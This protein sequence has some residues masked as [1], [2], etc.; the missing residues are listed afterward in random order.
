MAAFRSSRTARGLAIWA[1][2]AQL[3]FIA[4]WLVAGSIQP[5]YALWRYPIS[6]LGALGARHPWIINAGLLVLGS[7]FLALG[8]AVRDSSRGEGPRSSSPRC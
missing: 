5:G 6:D 8:V 1:I 7:S 2:A 3:V 4:S